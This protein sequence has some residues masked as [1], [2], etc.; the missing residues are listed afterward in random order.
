MQPVSYEGPDP[1]HVRL[2]NVQ[3]G[4]FEYQLEE[5]GYDDGGHTS[6]TIA[7]T[8]I[9]QGVHVLPDGT[10]IEVGT[11]STDHT[12]ASVG[13]SQEFSTTPVVLSQAQTR[14]G[15]Q[16]IVTRQR[17][18]SPSGLD[19]KVQE[20]EANGT[21]NTERVGYIAIDPGAGSFGGISFEAGTTGD[22][23]THDWQQVSF[24]GSYGG[25]PG[26]LAAMQTYAGPDAS[27]LRYRN[28]TSDSAEIRVEEERSADD[29]TRHVNAENV[30]YLVIGDDGLIY[31]E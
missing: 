17:D 10:T 23:V 11:V 19:V 26:F 22:V 20:A 12:F 31:A 29:E 24:G 4:S 5:W 18:V 6:E 21:H 13:F 16:P 2:R 7:Y 30:G 9:E 14:N 1:V 3:E 28:L 15:S 27:E 8:V 25:S